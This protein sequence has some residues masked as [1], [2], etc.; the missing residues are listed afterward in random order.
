MRY[1]AASQARRPHD[2][3]PLLLGCV[4]PGPEFSPRSAQ[5][6]LLML[7]SEEW[8]G[9]GGPQETTHWCYHERAPSTPG[10]F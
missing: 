1:G 7:A 8:I 10:G 2:D 3:P 4:S 5:E 9:R 6:L